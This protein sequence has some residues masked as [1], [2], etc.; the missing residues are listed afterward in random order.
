MQNTCARSMQFTMRCCEIRKLSSGRN[1]CEEEVRT[2]HCI[3][4]ACNLRKSGLY[5]YCMRPYIPGY[6]P[7]AFFFIFGQWI[8]IQIAV[9]RRKHWVRSSGVLHA[10]INI[11]RRKK[12]KV[13]GR[14]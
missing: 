11:F 5:A 10:A 3:G 9:G 13:I 2:L 4:K 14:H 7:I 6:I 12:S 8:F 1:I